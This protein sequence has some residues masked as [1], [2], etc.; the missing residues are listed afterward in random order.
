MAAG[1]TILMFGIGLV[2]LIWGSDL[3]V[4]SAVE[5]AGYFHISEV[6]IGATIVSLGT[7]LPEV[8]FSTTAA[9]RGLTDMALGNALGSILCNTGLIAGIMLLLS[10]IRLDKRAVGNLASGTFFLTAG[11]LV[12][13]GSGT[14]FG[15]LTRL[16]GNILLGICLLFMGY[17]LREAAGQDRRSGMP[18]DSGRSFGA[19][20][21][22][23]MALEVAAIYLGANLLVKYGPEL[24]R[25][26]GV[27]EMLI[28]LTFV[29]LGTSLPE[30]VTSLTA[31]RK[32]H[33]S[34]S[35]GNI[36]GADILNFVLV[37]GASSVICP[38]RYPDSILK[39]ELPFAFLLLSVLCVPSLRK[40]E[41]GRMQGLL[42]LA[43]YGLYLFL[44]KKQ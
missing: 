34:L 14:V 21:I 3:F 8:L 35:L 13:V 18:G 37:G 25:A 11:F 43:G 5:L 27:P 42:L 33:S 1:Y 2:L 15:G 20:D 19:G 7:T 36:I 41:A 38:I 39:L 29:A 30:L 26:M 10:P 24:A 17:T 44:M 32:K 23:R 31:W 9:W 12:Y 6:V 16:S 40:K 22:V 28:S 4:E